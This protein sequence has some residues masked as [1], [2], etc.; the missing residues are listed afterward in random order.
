MIPALPGVCGRLRVYN[1][2]PRRGVWDEGKA[3]EIPQLY[4]I[5]SLSW[6]KD[7]SRLCA[8][9]TSLRTRSTHACAHAAGVFL[10]NV[11]AWRQMGQEPIS[12]S[13]GGSW[14]CKTCSASTLLLCV[15]CQGTL[16]GGVE[17]FDC[18]LRRTNYKN[19]FEITYVSLNQVNG[20]QKSSKCKQTEKDGAFHTLVFTN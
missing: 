14:Y 7:G 1:W 12:T 3:K 15:C 5:S 13:S 9:N 4:T 17:I 8:V 20:R 2:A 18:C 6:K 16:C 11:L 10:L 19:K